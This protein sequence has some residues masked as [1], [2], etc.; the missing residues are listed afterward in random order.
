[1]LAKASASVAQLEDPQG[2][3]IYLFPFPK[4]ALLE[5]IFGINSQESLKTSIISILKTSYAH[6]SLFQAIPSEHSFD[7]DIVRSVVRD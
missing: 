4:E 3:Q 1:M 7:L 2:V 6:I 5:V